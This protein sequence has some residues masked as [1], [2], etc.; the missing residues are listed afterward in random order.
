MSYFIAKWLMIFRLSHA[1]S[2]YNE[3]N[4]LPM[5]VSLSRTS[6]ASLLYNI[7]KIMYVN[8]VV[9]PYKF[10]MDSWIPVTAEMFKM[11]MCFKLM[12]SQSLKWCSK[13]KRARGVG[14]FVAKQRVFEFFLGLFGDASSQNAKLEFNSHIIQT[15]FSSSWI[16]C[17][18]LERSH[19]LSCCWGWYTVYA[20]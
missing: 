11:K 12:T 13:L 14:N 9:S 8:L 20:L 7:Y 2:I 1:F 10:C 16:S 5:S 18:L 6:Y 19:Y 4:S 3:V 15:C 17:W